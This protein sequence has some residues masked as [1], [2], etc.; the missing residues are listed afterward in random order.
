MRNSKASV[1]QLLRWLYISSSKQAGIPVVFKSDE[2]S[3]VLFFKILLHFAKVA[4]HPLRWRVIH[5]STI[6]RHGIDHGPF[7]GRKCKDLSLSTLTVEEKRWLGEQIRL[8]I[9]LMFWRHPSEWPSKHAH[10]FYWIDW[11]TSWARD[12]RNS[13]LE[14]LV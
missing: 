7:Y 3:K 8:Q 12:L 9:S 10:G 4:L 13:L 2:C 11:L 14:F 5:M 1:L 6:N